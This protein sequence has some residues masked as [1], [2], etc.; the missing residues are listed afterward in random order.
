MR[1]KLVQCQ[2]IDTNEFKYFQKPSDIEKDVEI[3]NG[4]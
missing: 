4:A 3:M 1:L 2:N